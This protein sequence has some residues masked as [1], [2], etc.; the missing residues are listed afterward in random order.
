MCF[1]CGQPDTYRCSCEVTQPFCD[2]CAENTKCIEKIDSQ[3]VIYHFNSQT[4]SKL[5][6]LGLPNNTSVE[7]ILEAIDALIGNSFNVPFTPIDS[8]SVKWITGGTVGHAPK[9]EVIISPDSNNQAEVRNNGLFVKPYNENYYVK[10]NAIDAP[11]YLKDQIVGGSDPDGIVTIDV[12]DVN[13]LLTIKPVINVQCLLNTIRTQYA[14]EFCELVDSC[15]CFL[16]I[17]NLV[18]VFGPACPEG[19][20]LNEEETLCVGEN[21]VA[22]TIETETITACPV[23]FSQWGQYSALVYKNGFT[24]EGKGIGTSLT[25]DLTDGN[26]VAIS[27]DEVWKSSVYPP[28]TNN[29][30]PQ[31]RSA[32]WS[33]EDPNF[34]GTLGFVVPIDVPESKIYYVAISADN[35]FSLG[36]DGITLLNTTNDNTYW[37]DGGAKFRYWHIYPINLSEGIHYISISGTN[38]GSVGMFAAE[39]YNNTLSELQAASLEPSFIA[40]RAAYPLTSNVYSNLDLIFST[41]CAR[42]NGT[43][44]VGNASCPPGYNLDTSGGVL[45]PPCQGING[46]T[47]DW[48]CRQTLT[49]PFSGY[50]VTLVW[51]RI[52]NAINYQVQQKLTSEPDSEYVDSSVSPVANPGSGSTVSVTISGLESNQFDFRVRANF[53]SCSSEWVT[54]SNDDEC[55][56]VSFIEPELPQGQVAVPYNEEIELVGSAPFTLSGITKPSWMSIQIVGNSVIIGGTPDVSS[57]NVPIAFT[58]ENCEGQGNQSF[59]G[60][61]DVIEAPVVHDVGIFSND[62]VTICDGGQS[63]VYYRLP[64]EIGTVLYSDLGLTTPYTGNN[65]VVLQSNH[66]IYTIDSETGEITGTTG[67]SCLPSI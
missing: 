42:A 37:A 9:A 18:A 61:I 29:N 30:G 23:S 17:E 49:V 53:D 46:D 27:T 47:G 38:A 64:L 48:V 58:V 13:G 7:A 52:P 44:S 43:F 16:S 67:N 45:T 32:L 15:K 5:V 6:N 34:V 65:F 55:V 41:R 11:A 4:P 39:I 31:N 25:Q 10:V 59:S 19:Y 3:C 40:D 56:N 54:V 51:D 57:L 14:E 33:C 60:N 1:I 36:V 22:P 12:V 21:E 24:T 28:T 50:S 26:V 62:D 8:Q 63:D 35:E 66:I 2:Q 20:V